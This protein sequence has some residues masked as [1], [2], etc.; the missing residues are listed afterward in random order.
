MN[1]DKKSKITLAILLKSVLQLIGIRAPIARIYRKIRY[2]KLVL[3]YR[4]S[5]RFSHKMGVTYKKRNPELIVSL[6][7]IPQRI[8]TLHLCIESLLSQSIKPDI[9]TLWLNEKDKHGNKKLSSNDLPKSLTRLEKRGL[10]IE[11]CENIGSYCKLI[12]TIRKYPNALIVTADDD[13]L[14]PQNWLE[15]LYNAYLHE[16]QYIHCHI[17]H[18]IKYA[19]NK[20]PL[21]Y[22]EWDLNAIGH[23][24][25]SLD[26]FPTGAGGVIYAPHHLN[27]EVLNEKVFLEI[28][29]KA[30]DVWFKAMSLL[31][32]VLCKKTSKNTMILKPLQIK[33]NKTLWTGNWSDGGNDQQI[34]A[35]ASRYGLLGFSK[36]TDSLN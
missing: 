24:G 13:Q 28:C 3:P 26:I 11:W 35:V 15:Q 22:L 31:N 21:P 29:P 27:E 19:N 6:T 10:V 12:P 32:N 20:K 16:P 4:L 17:A 7:T 33:N 34:N 30:D 18:L 5:A 2:E 1:H 23:Q 36:I 9:I 14:Y 8:P 25:P